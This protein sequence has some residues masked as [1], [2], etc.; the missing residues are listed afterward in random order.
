MATPVSSLALKRGTPFTLCE[1]INAYVATYQGKDPHK[2]LKLEWFAEKLGDKVA[3]EIDGDDIQDALDALQRRGKYGIKTEKARP[4]KPATINRYRSTIQSVLTWGLKRRLMPRDWVNPVRE[5]EHLP[6]YNER[7]RYLSEGEYWRLLH[8]AKVSRWDK[9]HVL[10]KLAVTTGARRGTLLSL[11]WKDLDLKEK[12]AY[13]AH[14]KN[15]TPFVLVLQDDVVSEL[16]DLK[17]DSLDHELIFRGKS[18][19]KPMTIEKV[20]REA[21][22]KAHINGI[23]FHTLRH[24]HASWL[25]KQ[26]VPLL[27]IADSMG[28]KSLAMTKRYAHLCID[29]RVEILTRVF[30]NINK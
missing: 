16:E 26:G 15:G 22:K 25:A 4:L 24:T 6:E 11:S 28:H 18:S 8:A 5:T 20:W 9:L 23:S 13:A 14:T 17:G 12:R 10:I 29:N 27:A 30:A 2:L 19:N 7:V 3:H 1:L 21:V